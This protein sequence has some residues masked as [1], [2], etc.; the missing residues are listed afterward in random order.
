MTAPVSQPLSQP[1]MAANRWAISVHE[2][3]PQPLV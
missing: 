2:T 3:L 1:T